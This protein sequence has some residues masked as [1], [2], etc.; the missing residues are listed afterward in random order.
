MARL[1]VREEGAK[2]L[3]STRRRAKCAGSRAMLVVS[4]E[5]KASEEALEVCGQVEGGVKETVR[6]GSCRW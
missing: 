3:L 6:A 4:V 2:G 1:R 5:M